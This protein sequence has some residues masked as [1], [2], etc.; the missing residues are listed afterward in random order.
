MTHD[1]PSP[2]RLRCDELAALVRRVFA[3]R[4]SD[5]RIA[6]LCDLPDKFLPDH[7]VWLERRVLAEEWAA[8]LFSLE[9]EL[10]LGA[11][12]VLYRN[13]RQNNADLPEL[14]WRHRGGPLP[15][16]AEA[17]LHAAAEPFEKIFSEHQLIL[18]PT[19]LSTTAPLKLAAKRFGFR[20]ATMPGFRTAMIPALR[21]DYTEIDRRVRRLAEIL[22][23]ATGA[24][25][26]FTAAG[27]EHHLHLDLRHRHAHPSGGLITSPGTAGNL[28][29]GETYIVPYEG[30]LPDDP[31]RSAGVLPVE[32]EGEV[33][34]YRIAQNRAVEILSQGPVSAKEAR[35]LVDEPAYSNLAELGFG[36][37][38]DFGVQPMGEILLDEKLGLHIAFGR[39]DHFGGQVGAAQFSSPE[40]VVHIDR[41]YLPATQPHVQVER[42]DLARADGTTRPLMRGYEYTVEF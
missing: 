2:E 13:V 22:D 31:S 37:L 26:H 12:L 29:S 35:Y 3:P 19:E 32:L 21:L 34:L 30:E 20:A 36:V 27:E 28:P 9:G 10:G 14:A 6:V 11:S 38:S 18:A 33:V 5:R 4:K 15:R 17:L 23:E 8:E 7:P 25:L 24:D 40:A 16:D 42:V 41:V 39:S 1:P